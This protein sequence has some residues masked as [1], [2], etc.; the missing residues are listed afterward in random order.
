MKLHYDPT[1]DSLFIELGN[2]PGMETREIADGLNADFDASVIGIDID[3]ASRRLDLTTVDMSSLPLQAAC[4]HPAYVACGCDA[5]V[6][7]QAVWSI[8]RRLPS[9]SDRRP[10]VGPG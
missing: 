6:L 2:A 3:H 7:Q 4:P 8:C 5:P 1:T 9:N 10:G